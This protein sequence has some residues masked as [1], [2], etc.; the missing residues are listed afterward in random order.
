MHLSYPHTDK[1]KLGKLSSQTSFRNLGY[2]VR[3]MSY[4]QAKR[5]APPL[6]PQANRRVQRTNDSNADTR[7]GVHGGDGSN[8]IH[9]QNRSS[10][11][12]KS[13]GDGCR[14]TAVVQM[15]ETWLLQ[16]HQQMIR[17]TYN[18]RFSLVTAHLE[19]SNERHSPRLDLA[20]TKHLVDSAVGWRASPSRK[21]RGGAGKPPP[22][23]KLSGCAAAADAAGVRDGQENGEE[24]SIFT[25]HKPVPVKVSW[26]PTGDTVGTKGGRV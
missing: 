10:I 5:A 25:P 19:R 15:V 14:R 18:R 2:I 8:S 11:V 23:T 4:C 7:R 6:E 12:S 13:Q 16:E 3:P 22:H 26:Q 17:Q 21:P 20:E 24:T 9:T 1:G